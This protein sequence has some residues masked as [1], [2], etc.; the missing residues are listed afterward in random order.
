[1]PNKR[2]PQAMEAGTECKRWYMGQRERGEIVRAY[3]AGLS[4]AEITRRTG[5]S[6]ATITNTIYRHYKGTGRNLMQER[7]FNKIV[8][9]GLREWFI[10]SGASIAE[11][12]RICRVCPETLGEW[13][14]GGAR[15][16]MTEPMPKHAIDKILDW[17]GLTYEQ[18]FR[19]QRQYKEDYE[20]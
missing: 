2:T 11:A 17:T 20:A 1:M 15:G 16:A 3:E 9:P 6:S 10:Q 19:D 12:A 14:K 4:M 13:L 8:Y 18:A 7:T 5:R